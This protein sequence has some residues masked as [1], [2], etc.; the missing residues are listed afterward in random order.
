MSAS[1]ERARGVRRARPVA[2][3]DVGKTRVRVCAVGWEGELLAQSERDNCVLAGPPY[4]HADVEGLFDWFCDALRELAARHPIEALVPVTHGATAALIGARGL[5]LPVL[6][7]EFADLPAL[8]LPSGTFA[9]TGS[10]ALPAG[11][12]LARQLAWQEAAFPEAFSRVECILPYPQYWAWRFS[13]KRVSEITS[14][15]CH[16]HLWAPQACSFSALAVERGWER[17][18]PP[19]VE[20]WTSLGPLLPEVAQ[21]AGLDPACCVH[22]GIHDS[23]ASYLVQRVV[24]G[25]EPFAVVSTGTWVVCMARGV[26]LGCLRAELDMLANVDAFGEPVACMRFQGGREYAAL[27]GQAGQ[28]L[29]ADERDLQGVI[30]SGAL[31]LPSYSDQGG[32]FA[33]RRGEVTPPA[34]QQPRA[35]AALASLYCALMIDLCLDCLG[36]RGEVVLEGRMAANPAIAAVL[37]ALRAPQRC[38]ASDDPTGTLRGAALLAR[39]SARGSIAATVS[40]VAPLPLAGL[41]DYRARWRAR[42]EDPSIG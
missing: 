26:P 19:R 34:P 2:V 27:A 10:P 16:T 22:A 5:E 13:G 17:L 3:L 36:A 41:A 40:P 25:D 21:R 35:R 30:A 29:T 20:A 8:E 31:A 42:V 37:G 39:W 1:A 7:Y 33:S 12:N 38:L 11:L 32:P 6:D 9:Q 24:R 23:N 18:F 15:G 28:A 14:L 4:P